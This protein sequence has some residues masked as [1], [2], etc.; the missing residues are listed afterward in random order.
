[1]ILTAFNLLS[2]TNR[3]KF[4]T[5]I[6][7]FFSVLGKSQS[8]ILRPGAGIKFFDTKTD[9]SLPHK[10]DATFNGK[11]RF[12]ALAITIAAELQFKKSSYEL[13][14]T[15]QQISSAFFTEFKEA[16][17]S[18]R[19]IE[20]GGISQFQFIYNRFIQKKIISDNVY[21]FFGLGFGIGIN[22]PS[23]I[24]DS[25]YYNSRFYSSSSPNDFIDLSEQDKSLSKLSYS[26]VLKAGLCI[27]FHN[28]ER[29]RIYGIYNLG[30]NK[31][32]KTDIHYSHSQDNYYG[33]T[34]TKGSQ[35]SLML[36]CPIYIKRMR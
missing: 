29:L 20:N 21:P 25:S 17:I 23:D 31:I 12:S 11:H 24:Y 1:M 13:I 5:L 2:L 30:L 26:F 33:T 7:L 3:K 8:I 27:K 34:T 6:V 10:L 16:G 22:R 15:S 35:F 14:F 28:I 32:V 19:Y 9:L 36:T 18:E 4:L